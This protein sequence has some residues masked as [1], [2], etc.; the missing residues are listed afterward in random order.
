MST[1]VWIED[2]IE[3]IRPLTDRLKSKHDVDTI[4]LANCTHVLRFFQ[5][6]RTQYELIFLDLWIPP[7]SDD[8]SADEEAKVP[9]ELWTRE[10]NADRAVWLFDYVE[11]R[12][13]EGCPIYVLSGNLDEDTIE[14]LLARGMTNDSLLAK[15][16]EYDRLKSLILR[17][18]E[19]LPGG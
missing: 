4:F 1:I 13:L 19:G 11:Q 16:M 17:N 7:I 6:S 12:R 10:R 18:L 5:S 3:K 14:H 8:A 15:P 9:I 2:H